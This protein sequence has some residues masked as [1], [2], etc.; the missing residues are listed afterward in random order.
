MSVDST[1]KMLGEGRTFFPG[2]SDLSLS[3]WHMVASSFSDTEWC[4]VTPRSGASPLAASPDPP[5]SGYPWS[6]DHQCSTFLQAA[7]KNHGEGLLGGFY[8]R[9]SCLSKMFSIPHRRLPGKFC[10]HSPSS[11]LPVS[12]GTSRPQVQVTCSLVPAHHSLP[13]SFG[14]LTV[15]RLLPWATSPSS[16]KYILQLHHLR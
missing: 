3:F 2:S 14:A 9:H 7:P 11:F 16:C 12:L 1:G 8:R 15:G 5:K 6:S 10:C 4:H 13:A